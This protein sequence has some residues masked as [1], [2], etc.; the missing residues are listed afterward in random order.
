[1]PEHG[2]HRI[3]YIASDHTHLIN[4][5]QLQLLKKRSFSLLILIFDM[6]PIL[7]IPPVC[8]P[9]FGYHWKRMETRVI[10]KE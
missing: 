8:S 6:R 5:Q 3:Q 1:M 10:G 7:S 9:V 4:D 2:I